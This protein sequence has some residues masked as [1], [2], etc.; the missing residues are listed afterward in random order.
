MKNFLT[1]E[2]ESYMGAIFITLLAAFFIGLLF[3]S[4]KNLDSDITIITSEQVQVKTISA[5][6]RELIRNWVIENK[7]EIPKG[8]GY[9]YLIKKYPSRPWLK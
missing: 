7:V 2:V 5:T 3:I 9:R 4:I 6:E 8:V 1:I